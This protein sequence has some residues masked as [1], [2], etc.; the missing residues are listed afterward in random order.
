[1]CDCFTGFVPDSG[2]PAICFCACIYMCV[3]AWKTNTSLWCCLAGGVAPL[4]GDSALRRD[5]LWD[6]L[7]CITCCLGSITGVY[8]WSCP[9]SWHVCIQAGVYHFIAACFRAGLGS[10]VSA[11]G[12]PCFGTAVAVCRSHFPASLAW[13]SWAESSPGRGAAWVQPWG[14]WVLCGF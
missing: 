5:A 1:M 14:V 13:W 4:R 8:F 10:R 6:A 12:F 7:R 3:C 9:P 11:R 2:F